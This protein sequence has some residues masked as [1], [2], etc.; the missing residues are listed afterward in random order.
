MDTKSPWF[1]GNPAS[2]GT[3]HGDTFVD[4]AIV[5]SGITGITAATLLKSAG[6]TVAL[7]D[8]SNISAGETGYTTAHL[9]EIIDTRYHD[10]INDF[11]IEGARMVAQSSRAAIEMI[12]SLSQE[13]GIDCQLTSL[14]AY[15][16]TE[17]GDERTELMDELEACRKVGIL[18]TWVGNVPLPFKTEG[19][20]R[21]ENQ[22]QFHPRLYLLPL[23]KKIAGNGS[24]VFENTR[25]DHVDD[26]T[27][28]KVHTDRG[29]ITARDVI[30]CT[31]SPVNNW[32]FLHTKLPAYR[33]YALGAKLKGDTTGI[34]GLYWDTF[35]PY[36]YTR[37]AQIPGFGEI[38]IVGGE[39]H[40]TGTKEN[41]AD[42]F[43]HLEQ[44]MRS[45]FN[46]ESIP[47]RWSGQ[48]LEPLDGLP[49]IGKNS[50]SEHIY[51]AAGYSGNGMTFGTLAGMI[52]SDLIS[53]RKN[54]WADLYD[55]TR[56]HPMA[57]AKEFIT[58]NVDF[59]TYFIKDRLHGADV[60]SIS[61]VKSGEGKIV[62]HEGQ[63]VAAYRDEQGTL[64]ACSAVC[65]HMGCLVHFNN[66]ETT[67]DCPCH[68]SRFDVDGK[69][70]NGPA[71]SDLE[72]V[73]LEGKPK[74]RRETATR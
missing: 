66:A 70:A 74:R 34:D 9:T 8:K 48:I 65:P 23:A 72:Q 54:K 20:I 56:F 27:P 73:D 46:V 11:G 33:T 67:W 50:L 24:F 37:K 31:N 32:I 26:G 40:K 25:V 1:E 7:I 45:R 5:G 61:D 17:S 63:K 30:V 53:G 28:C 69:V 29:S 6:K 68:G 35:D 42:C 2:F 38:V 62:N 19:G 57:S 51:V 21:F 43:Q 58:E 41:T 60:E 59:P 10:L 14:P 47:F 18:A 4:V 15:L 64:H 49:Y 55:A 22:A 36:H 16:Y 71:V 3:L 44:Y 52:L 13:H 39:D 12:E